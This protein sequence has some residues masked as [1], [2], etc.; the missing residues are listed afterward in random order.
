MEQIDNVKELLDLMMQPAFCVRDG[1]IIYVNYAASQRQIPENT[2][3]AELLATG[4]QEYE[5][6]AGGNLYL[7]LEIAGAVCGATVTR[8]AAGD[9]F[10]LEQDAEQAELNAMALAAQELREPLASIMTV[11]DRLF[12]SIEP[13]GTADTQQQIAQ[14]NR[15][16]FQML[17]LVGN[18]TDAGLYHKRSIAKFEMCNIPA[19]VDELFAKAADMVKGANRQ[20]KFTGIRHPVY[21]LADRAKLERAIYNLLSNA[22]KFSPE[23]TTIVAKLTQNKD[24][25]YFSIQDNGP[26]VSSIFCNTVFSRFIRGPGIED[27]RHGVGLGMV[28]VRSVATMHGGTVLIDQ[29]E[30]N[31]TRVTMS[32][33]LLKNESGIVRSGSLTV[34]YAG[35]RDHALIE[36]SDALPTS[37]YHKIN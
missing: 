18:M 6:Y 13:Q 37:L 34:D 21:G 35:E 12:P 27:G 1:L 10:L 24:K 30:G 8:T 32:F 14:I 31:G 23:G 26:G 15:G 22:I 20:L 29:P 16:L 2:A 28:L 5:A 4:A 7:T 17:R 25:L 11:V 3:V 19:I 33:T 9:I 36:L